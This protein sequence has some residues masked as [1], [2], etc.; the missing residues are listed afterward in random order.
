MTLNLAKRLLA[1][2]FTFLLAPVAGWCAGKEP[3]GQG[4]LASTYL[5]TSCFKTDS[6]TVQEVCTDY[7]INWKLWILM[8]EPVGDYKLA[9]T[10]TGIRLKG[11]KRDETVWIHAAE[12]PKEL[13]KAARAIELYID[14]YATVNMRSIRHRF[15]TGAAV[16]A[17]A[18]S[19]YNVPGSPNW[20][21]VFVYNSPCRPDASKLWPVDAKTAQGEFKKGIS[22]HSLELCPESGVSELTALESAID[23]LCSK[24]GADGKFAFCPQQ[25]KKE[26]KDEARQDASK[27]NKEAASNKTNSKKDDA[28]TPGLGSSVLDGADKPAPDSIHNILDE[29]AERSVIQKKLV[30]E[31]ASYHRAAEAACQSIMRDIE[32]CYTR[33]Q[34]SRP[35]PPFGVSETECDQAR[36]GNVVTHLYLTSGDCD[37]EC[38]EKSARLREEGRER[39]AREWRAKWG[40]IKARCEPY[41]EQKKHYSQCE[42]SLRQTCNPKGLTMKDCTNEQVRT[43]GPTEKDV[44]RLMQKEWEQRSKT[45]SSITHSILD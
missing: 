7:R 23:K 6:A 11:R 38:R 13:Q 5:T 20:N 44:R 42:Q 28:S 9:W 29:S 14:G 25:E 3:G 8:G 43:K 19:S 24:P 39:E 27:Q 17:G 31:T 30:Q 4:T 21:A 16:K 26:K 22:I 35:Q 32:A 18:G 12:L 15:N 37:K 1:I 34:C 36:G 40:P 10:L 33:A 41:Y 2:V 45:G